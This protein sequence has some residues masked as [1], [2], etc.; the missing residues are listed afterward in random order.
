MEANKILDKEQLN[1]H[2]QLEILRKKI[3]I[4][5]Q[6]ISKIDKENN[7]L[8]A[9]LLNLKKDGNSNKTLTFANESS[10]SNL[11]C[12]ESKVFQNKENVNLSIKDKIQ[13]Y[14]DCNA[15]GKRV[16]ISTYLS[17]KIDEIIKKVEDIVGIKFNNGLIL[18]Y[19]LKGKRCINDGQRFSDE[20]HTLSF[21]G[22]VNNKI[23]Q[24]EYTKDS[25]ILIF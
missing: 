2:N 25:N 4:D 23:L 18:N 8:K 21:Y 14:V 22:I 6:Y 17:E 7:F 13:I 5:S 12:K 20:F 9:E 24:L 16:T 19:W 10:H 3:E 1:I 11:L 15:I